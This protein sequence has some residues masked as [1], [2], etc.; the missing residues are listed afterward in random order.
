MSAITISVLEEVAAERERQDAKWGEQ[1]H[2]LPFYFTIFAEEVGEVAKAVVEHE[3]A[4]SLTAAGEEYRE[5][6]ELQVRAELIQAAAVAV[7]MV[8]RI[9]RGEAVGPL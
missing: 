2:R 9:D 5:A 8:E 4:P 3:S 7:A 1:N 6:I